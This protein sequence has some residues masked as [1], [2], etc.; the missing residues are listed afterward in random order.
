MEF[1]EIKSINYLDKI[2]RE[3]K[4]QNFEKLTALYLEKIILK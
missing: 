3:V 1:D 4:W 2:S